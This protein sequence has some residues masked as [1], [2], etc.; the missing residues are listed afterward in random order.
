MKISLKHQ[1]LLILLLALVVRLVFTFLFA[2]TY[3]G[4]ED[5]Y[6]MGDS[7][8]YINN[9]TNLVDHGQYRNVL[10]SPKSVAGRLPGYPL[11]IS[12]LY[13]ISGKNIDLTYQLIIYIQIIVDVLS[14][15]LFYKL[16]S[17]AT[18][19]KR[20]GL[21]AMMLYAFYPFVIVWVPVLATELFSLFFMLLG[22][23]LLARNK[24]KWEQLLAGAV[25]AFCVYLRPQ[26]LAL[27]FFFVLVYFI[28]NIKNIKR[29]VIPVMMMV[30]GFTLVYSPWVIRNYILLN[31]RVL[32]Y[33]IS[34]SIPT[35]NKDVV[36]VRKYI[37]SVKSDWNP[38][39]FQIVRN[40]EVDWPE[41]AF[42]SKEDSIMLRRAEYLAKNCGSGISHWSEYW[43][44][45]NARMPDSISCNDSIA[46]YFS[47]LRKNQIK[48]NPFHYYV[49]I[50]LQN[51]K[52]TI[53]KTK[54][55][56]ETRSSINVLSTMLFFYRSFLLILGLIG[57][58]FMIKR[59]NMIAIV[60][61][62]FWATVSFYLSFYSRNMEM[63]YLL[64]NDVLMLLPAAYLIENIYKW[65]KI[66]LSNKNS[67]NYSREAL[68]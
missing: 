36:V 41:I 54:L 64:N 57:V 13:I 22:L 7:A 68:D 12:L 11:I 32:F 53:F 29:I 43:N 47:T 25:L 10:D 28:F 49:S 9:A 33:K 39:F 14:T 30:L 20:I 59:K 46:Y 60:I 42:V 34:G 21:I 24:S 1:I 63:R 65:V 31:E 66:K 2:E 38:Q 62:L 55:S 23:L 44:K 51:F 48:A 26:N 4:K 40:E 15:F 8:D 45:E 35:F 50:P 18:K 27:F 17:I 37:Y 19:N 3:F 16:A 61:F 5:F 56:S 67:D 58:M 6:I 52:K